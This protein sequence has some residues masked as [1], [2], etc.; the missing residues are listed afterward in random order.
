MKKILTYTFISTSIM[1]QAWSSN[2][3]NVMEID[4]PKTAMLRAQEE[5]WTIQGDLLPFTIHNHRLA[6]YAPKKKNNF[7]EKITVCRHKNENT[8]VYFYLKL[9]LNNKILYSNLNELVEDLTSPPVKGTLHK[10]MAGVF[11]SS[12]KELF[13]EFMQVFHRRALL[14]DFII[15]IICQKTQIPDFRMTSQYIISEVDVSLGE[16]RT[17]ETFEKEV[18]AKVKN[19]PYTPSREEVIRDIIKAFYD[20]EYIEEFNPNSGQMEKVVYVQQVDESSHLL[21]SLCSELKTIPLDIATG[22]LDLMLMH[23]P[24]DEQEAISLVSKLSQ[25]NQNPEC[26]WRL[27][28]LYNLILHKGSVG[29]IPQLNTLEAISPRKLVGELI[30]AWRKDRE[31]KENALSEK[32]L[33]IEKQNDEIDRL[34]QKLK[35]AHEREVARLKK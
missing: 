12:S 32:D 28:R 18:L 26:S 13:P 19:M 1:A 29:S 33:K 31:E 3:N 16:E 5:G 8:V 35:E 27:L 9:G 15:E 11:T 24:K 25:F 34:K 14:P 2:D 4:A 10:S 7:V 30:F 23:C 20:T 22:C 17:P 21:L 6:F